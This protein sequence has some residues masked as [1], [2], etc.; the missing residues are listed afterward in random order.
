MNT[1]YYHDKFNV[2]RSWRWWLY[3]RGLLSGNNEPRSSTWQQ[4]LCEY[5]AKKKKDSVKRLTVH[6][7]IQKVNY[8]VKWNAALCL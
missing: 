7:Y 1:L 4:R 2:Y 3:Y 6:V 8:S 5:Y